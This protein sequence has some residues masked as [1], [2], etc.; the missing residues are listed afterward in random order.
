MHCP[1]HERRVCQV[2]SCGWIDCRFS[3]PL[4]NAF[5][6]Y[7]DPAN[8]L[9]W[10]KVEAK[11]ETKATADDEIF[12]IQALRA[13]CFSALA[14][15]VTYLKYAMGPFIPVHFLSEIP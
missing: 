1:I 7:M 6:G 8:E 11:R 14:E 9:T 3:K 2:E 13:S 12:S 10:K 15:M 5:L 4:M